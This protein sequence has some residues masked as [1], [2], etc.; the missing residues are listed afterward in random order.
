MIL[1]KWISGWER[2]RDNTEVGHDLQRDVENGTYSFRLSLIYLPRFCIRQVFVPKTRQVHQPCRCFTESVK[3]ERLCNTRRQSL[4]GFDSCFIDCFKFPSCRYL[5]VKVLLCEH[6]RPVHKIAEDS[7]QLM[8]I[9]FC[10][11]TFL[12]MSS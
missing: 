9:T 12:Q 3:L 4:K 10:L 7:N 8:A 6:Q 1:I 11:I 2:F 5:V